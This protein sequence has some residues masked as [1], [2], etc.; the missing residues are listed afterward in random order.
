MVIGLSAAA[1]T[2]FLA[3]SPPEVLATVAGLALLAALGP[4]LATA[5]AEPGYREAALIT[6]VVAASGT[7]LL[8]VTSAFWGLVAGLGF[9]G[10]QRRTTRTGWVFQLA[11]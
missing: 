6:F 5:V 1:A 11:G 2:A 7:T 9:V 4:A 3:A 8:T 10:L